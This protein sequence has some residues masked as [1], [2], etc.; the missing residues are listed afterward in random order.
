MIVEI[1]S[2]LVFVYDLVNLGSRCA[3]V[4]AIDHGA[5]YM[6]IRTST[7]RQDPDPSSLARL[8]LPNDGFLVHLRCFYSLGSPDLGLQPEA[9]NSSASKTVCVLSLSEEAELLIDMKKMLKRLEND[10]FE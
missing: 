8:D 1:D 10:I 9:A 5:L 7:R 6:L 4:C 2:S 3:P